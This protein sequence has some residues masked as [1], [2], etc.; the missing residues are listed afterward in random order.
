MRELISGELQS[1][2]GVFQRKVEKMMKKYVSPT[3]LTS[4]EVS[5][6]TNADV[7]MIV[8]FVV[9]AAA[10]I[11]AVAKAVETFDD[12]VMAESVKCIRKVG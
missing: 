11:V 9:A 1:F 2:I 5:N 12:A 10:A 8:P 7:V 4:D 6:K 3:I